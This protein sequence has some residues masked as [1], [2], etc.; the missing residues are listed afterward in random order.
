MA[1]GASYLC[2]APLSVLV[3]VAQ[4]GR[5]GGSR[6]PPSPGVALIGTFAAAATAALSRPE[7]RE[8]GAVHVPA[9]PRPGLSFAGVSPAFW[10]L[11]VGGLVLVVT[12]A[13]RDRPAPRTR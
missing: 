11:V 1:C 7:H 10:A 6:S 3:T 2:L 4:R 9:W 8:A 12:G 13:G 5:A